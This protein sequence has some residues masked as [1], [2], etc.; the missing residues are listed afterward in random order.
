MD[1]EKLT[2]QEEKEFSEQSVVSAFDTNAY[3]QNENPALAPRIPI[4]MSPVIWSN[5]FR[6]GLQVNT[7]PGVFSSRRAYLSISEM[8]NVV[9]NSQF[10][11][12]QYEYWPMPILF[13]L[14]LQAVTCIAYIGLDSPGEG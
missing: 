5:F 1:F 9:Q 8:Q 3:G 13:A 10:A 12:D 7:I 14:R 4:A 2:M 6:E 11:Y